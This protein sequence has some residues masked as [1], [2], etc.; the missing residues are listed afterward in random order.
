MVPLLCQNT[1]QGRCADNI[2]VICTADAQCGT[3]C[4]FAAKASSFFGESRHQAVLIAPPR[5]PP[6]SRLV[7]TMGLPL[8]Q[9]CSNDGSACTGSG[10][11]CGGGYCLFEAVKYQTLD[12]I[13]EYV[14]RAAASQQLSLLPPADAPLLQPFGTGTLQSHPCLELRSCRASST[15]SRARS[16]PS[17]CRRLR[18]L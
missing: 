17:T 16:T 12:T 1:T 9:R 8:L 13:L 18:T 6:F 11:E 3:T 4:E 2:A 15:R 14:M 7:P 10:S 5:L